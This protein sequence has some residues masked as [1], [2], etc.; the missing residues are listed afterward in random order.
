MYRT[1]P[2]TPRS[3]PADTTLTPRSHL[4]QGSRFHVKVVARRAVANIHS[5][6]DKLRLT[7]ASAPAG[8]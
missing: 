8:V 4:A 3:D 2:L 6:I 5:T 1:T 7:M